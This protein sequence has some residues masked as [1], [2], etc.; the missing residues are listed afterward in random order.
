MMLF[1]QSAEV[2]LAKNLTPAKAIKT[3]T[4]FL[5]NFFWFDQLS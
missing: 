3:L 2:K 1:N 5:K 4:C